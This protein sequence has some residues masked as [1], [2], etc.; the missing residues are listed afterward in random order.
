MLYACICICMCVCICVCIKFFSQSGK[1][2]PPQDMIVLFYSR[3]FC[4][5]SCKST[6]S[7]NLEPCRACTV[8]ATG[9][10][11]YSVEVL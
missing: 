2:K 1:T 10:H 4:I 11:T 6:T 8:T 9:G 5:C 3:K 7:K